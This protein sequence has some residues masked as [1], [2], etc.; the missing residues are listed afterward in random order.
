MSP[1]STCRRPATSIFHTVP[2]M[3]A[4]MSGT[5]TPPDA[6]GCAVGT[7]A[8]G[9]GR[10]PD[11]RRHRRQRRGGPARRRRCTRCARRS[12]ARAWSSPTTARATRPPTW[13]APRAPRSCG[14][15][16]RGQGRGGDAGGAE[17]ALAQ[18]PPEPRAALRRR[19][20]GERGAA[21]RRWSTPSR[22]GEGDLAVAAFARRVGGGFGIAVGFAHW[23]IRRPDR[24]R[25]CARR[26][27]ASARCGPRCCRSSCR[28]RRAS[29]WRSG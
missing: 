26:S 5:R 17:C 2:V 20:G 18:R 13:R 16:G 22:A 8:R 12:R 3:W 19:P 6:G 14:S 29:G 27:P 7:I 9:N 28:S 15:R 23:A 24:A 21:A 1:S 10:L 4:S 25:R 11:R